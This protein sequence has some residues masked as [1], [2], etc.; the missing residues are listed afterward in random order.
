MEVV[1]KRWE[2]VRSNG[3]ILVSFPAFGWSRTCHEWAIG[4][5]R[6]YLRHARNIPAQDRLEVLAWL[7]QQEASVEDEI[8]EADKRHGDK[9]EAVFWSLFGLAALIVI[10]GLVVAI[11]G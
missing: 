2:A 10:V 9:A 8:A 11:G 6:V 3:L 1:T 5:M 7:E 4:T